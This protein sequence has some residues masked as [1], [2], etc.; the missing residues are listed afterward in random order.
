[1]PAGDRPHPDEIEIRSPRD[2]RDYAAARTLIEDYAATL[3]VDLSFQH[4]EEELTQLSSMYA[5]P[6]ADLLLAWAGADAVGCIAVRRHDD[7][8]A[9]MKRLYVRPSHRGRGLGVRLARGIS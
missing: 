3:G 7:E 2:A 8:T 1:M 9:E 5:P 6:A 4:F